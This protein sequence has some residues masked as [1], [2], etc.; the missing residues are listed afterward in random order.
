MKFESPLEALKKKWKRKRK[1]KQKRKHGCKKNRILEFSFPDEKIF[2]EFS[3]PEFTLFF[4][5]KWLKIVFQP[6]REEKLV[7]DISI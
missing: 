1:Q 4:W 3:F 2:C 7:E 5:E 6:K